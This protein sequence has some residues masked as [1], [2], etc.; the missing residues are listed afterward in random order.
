MIFYTGSYTME[1]SPATDPKG[2]GIGCFEFDTASG[3]IKLLRYNELQNPSYLIIS[4]DQK[5]LY[6]VEEM[7][8]TQN[9][10]IF[11]YHIGDNG[12]LTLVNFQF[13]TGDHACHL[14]LVQDQLIIANYTTGNALS[15]PVMKDGSLG[16]CHQV[17][18]HRGNG[19]NPNRQEGPH[20]HMVY[21]FGEDHI[22]LVDLGI[23]KAKAYRLNSKTQNW[24]EVPELD[25]TLESGAGARHMVMNNAER[26]AY[27]LSELLGDIFVFEKR[28]KGFEQIQ[29]ISFVPEDYKGDYG[30]AAIR[31]HPNE[32]F[33]YASNRGPDT[34]SIFEIDTISKKLSLVEHS[35]SEGET[36]RDFNIDP[37]GNWLVSA[38][39]DSDTLVVFKID[40]ESGTLDKVATMTVGTPVNISWLTSLA[41]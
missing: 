41:K 7:T 24:E 25:I 11:S 20:A 31:M 17:I 22:F 21:P 19:T 15:F 1:G 30:G 3:N 27:V 40:Y 5:Y 13:L 32:K 38:N 4:K 28:N 29:K 12:E 16:P 6:A 36:P 34:I 23:D 8:E 35:S 37:T 2:L 14:A 33:L 18:Q 26:H 9:P 39:Q 10:K